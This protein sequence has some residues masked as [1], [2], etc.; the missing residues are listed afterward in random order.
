[1]V[2][3][4]MA[5]LDMCNVYHLDLRMDRGKLCGESISETDLGPTDLFTRPGRSG[6]PAGIEVEHGEHIVA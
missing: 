2:Y 3:I 4:V 1:M 6:T 5:T